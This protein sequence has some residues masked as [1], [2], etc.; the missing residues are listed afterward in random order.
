MLILHGCLIP[1]IGLLRFL[2]GCFPLPCLVCLFCWGVFH[3]PFRCLSSR[4]PLVICITG[5]YWW[6][7]VNLLSL[8]WS[9]F[10]VCP[11]FPSSQGNALRGDISMASWTSRFR[12]FFCEELLPNYRPCSLWLDGFSGPVVTRI[13]WRRIDQTLAMKI[14]HLSYLILDLADSLWS[15]CTN[16]VQ[17]VT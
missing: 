3:H 13:R 4:P 1:R 15:Q 6:P 9:D 11:F 16:H 10:L 7:L 2:W 17:E 5:K 8:L 14:S 12:P